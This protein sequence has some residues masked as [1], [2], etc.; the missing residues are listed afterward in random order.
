MQLLV[1]VSRPILDV[2]EDDLVGL[3]P[4]QNTH[5]RRRE[6][7]SAAAKTAQA[8]EPAKT[9]PAPVKPAPAVKVK[10]E[11][12]SES[13]AS[14]KESTPVPSGSKKA[15]PKRGASGGIMQ[16]FAKAAAMPKKASTSIPA[17]PSAAEDA[18]IQGLAL[19]DDGEDDSAA[20]P[21]PKP[22]PSQEIETTGKSRK[23]RQDELKRMM[24]ESSEDEEPEKEDTPMEEAE[25]PPAP[26]EVKKEDAEPAEVVSST[27][28]G[29]RRGK[30]QV[31][32]KKT[33]MDPEGY[34]GKLSPRV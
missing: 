16:S 18:D 14:S 3:R 13:K 29:R 8:P 1:D 21:E 12:K 7:R 19:S 10:E 31:I 15:A 20:M 22:E 11:P 5:V 4:V 28:D 34:L 27:G 2:A 32:K 33:V 26:E 9:K 17:T 30:R 25:E 6:R 24:E 23:A